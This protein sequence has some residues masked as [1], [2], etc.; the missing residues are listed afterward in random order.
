MKNIKS[1]KGIQILSKNDQKSLNGAAG[2]EG[3]I[4]RGPMC[5]TSP[6]PRD[7]DYGRCNGRF[8]LWF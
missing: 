6:D 2:R 4:Q 8:C 3:C 7:C 5:C 1:L